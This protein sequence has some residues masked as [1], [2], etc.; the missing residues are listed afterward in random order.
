MS[1][2]IHDVL[3]ELR[4]AA[5]D[6][7][8]KGDKFERLI[9]GYLRTDPQWARQFDNVWLWME[10]PGREGRPDTGIDLVASDRESGELTAIQCKF[11]APK[12]VVQK[13]DIDS[14]FTA[15]GK[16]SFS[17]RIVVS[18]TDKWSK[19]AQES[20]VDQQ[21]S[22]QRLDISWLSESTI[23]WDA[24][25]WSTP[26]VMPTKGPK[27]LLPH[28][29]R[30][31][32]HVRK[33]LGEVDR[34]ILIMACGTGKTFTS[35]KIAEELVGA[36][37]SVLFLVPSI[38]LLSQAL[39]EWMQEASASLRP[40]AVCS[41]VRVGRRQTEDMGVI[42]LTEP[43]TTSVAKLLERMNKSSSDERMT[44]IFSTYQSI[45]VV[46]DA[47]RAGLGEFELVICDE[48]HRTTGVT[49]VGED[50]SAFVRVHDQGFLRAK[51]RLYMTATPRLYD[52]ASKSKAAEA[53]V[54]I[55]SMD[56][57]S[58]YGP[59]LHRLGFGEA[60][61]KGLLADYKVLVL[62]VD[63]KSV[64][65]QFQ[66]LL[67]DEN[68]ELTL[69]D[70]AKIVGCWNGLAKRELD[71]TRLHANTV[72]MR[73]AV[74][75]AENIKVSQKI[76]RMFEE[77]TDQLAAN[78]NEDN[79][80]TCEAEH[81]DGTFN[82]LKRNALL[83]WLKDNQTDGS[84][85]CRIL[86]N[87]RCLSEGVDVP[88]LDAV[89]FL[90]PRNSVVDVVQSVG[91]VMR[92]PAGKEYGY[93]IL[94]IGIPADVPPEQ[95]LADNKR[96]RVVWQVLQALRAH[97]DRFN[98]MVNKIE[99]NR[100]KD[101]QLQVIG[102]GGTGQHEREPEQKGNYQQGELALSWSDEWCD[103]IY[104][105]IVE[106]VGDRRYW[107]TWA[108]D[109]AEIAARHESRIKALLEHPN[110]DVGNL[111]DR[112]H[113]GLKA[114]LNDGITRENAIEMLAQH[115]ITK[116]VFGALFEGYDF[117]GH[118]PI[119]LVMQDMLDALDEQGI[120][121]E[122]ETLEK[123]YA[124][125]QLRAA[126]I[127]NAEGKQK[128]INDLYEK[129]FKTAFPKAAASLGIVYTPIQI[130]DFIL[131]SV[132]HL[133]GTEFGSSLNNEDV[134]VLDPFTGT[135]TFIARLLQSGLISAA[136]LL[137][138]YA[139]ELH[140]NE[141]NLLAYYIAAVNIEATFHGIA[142]GSYQPFDGIVLTDTFQMHEENDSLDSLIF[143]Q[144]NERVLRQLATP[145]R[146]IV[147]NPPYSAGQSSANDDNANLK[148]PTLDARIEG[149]YAARSTATL[150]N[151]LYDSYIRAIRWASDRIG[152]QGIVAFVSNGGYIDSNTA[153]GLRKCLLDEFDVV[154]V[155]NLR[156][157]QRTAGELSRKEGGKIFGGGSRATIAILFLV[158]T[159]KN[160]PGSPTVLHYR[161]I[162]DYLTREQK[163]DIVECD[164][165]E[166]I[167]W[168]TIT[169]NA[170]GDWINQ[171]RT[172]YDAYIPIGDKAKQA[173]F[174]LYS[175]GLNTSRDSWSY[176]FS[177][178]RLQGV[179]ARSI[180]FFNSEVKRFKTSASQDA[181]RF[182]D[183]DPAKFSWDVAPL[184]DVEAG[185]LIEVDSTAFR[186]ACYRPFTRSN[187]YFDRRLV[188]RVYQLPRC[189][190]T[191]AQMNVG[192]YN[193]GAGSDV[194]FSVLMLDCVPDRH[195]TGA[196]SGGNFYPRYIYRE[197]SAEANL[198]SE[199]AENLAYQRVDNIT[200]SAL[201][202]FQASYG[203]SVTKDDIFFY[204][205]GL[206]HSP[207]YRAQ[208]AAD[209]K[210]M[211]PRIP[212]VND[213]LGFT[214]AGRKL[215]DLHLGYEA[216]EL[217]ELQEVLTG[218]QD[219]D[220]Y[221]RYRVQKM[222]FD[223]GSRVNGKVTRDR[224]RIV[225]N[226][227]ITLAGIPEDAYGYM[228]GSRSAIEWIMDRYQIRTDPSSGIVNDP[229]N[230]A[231]EHEQ[232]RYILDL[233][234]RIVTVSVATMR[235]AD[236]LPALDILS[237]ESLSRISWDK[238]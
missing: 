153:D 198:F 109:I 101:A 61:E 215:A 188:N 50:E 77:V 163:L 23:E 134:H 96:Y 169:P 233:L 82:V 217:Y 48:A 203:P 199:D 25:S 35:L 238:Q 63:Q 186:N 237:A 208:Y 83:D 149:T 114:N 121:K 58:L 125:V 19:H 10:W 46:S 34:G 36:G 196:G 210:K 138:K 229:N 14:F 62:A 178:P 89:L 214:N 160:A 151:S 3:A 95:A 221:F 180:D 97:D 230:W 200:D 136:N 65:A 118:N 170:H 213:F 106:K 21:I 66:T 4:S 141:I 24:F 70:A 41:D 194:P 143:P 187:V 31:L 6:E 5:L 72:P 27:L 142:G 130:V 117:T 128:I 57:E 234:K 105:K 218:T 1:A 165:I 137:R 2:T 42:D 155:Y 112:F 113:T 15:S 181:A 158:K 236:N 87:A 26:T 32:Q 161:D 159:G 235:I 227:S 102:V 182:V 184:R 85:V 127:D 179:V 91:R 226:S 80:L 225:Y 231:R 75:F 220:E 30:A 55:A 175:G 115:I 78:S 147:G 145:I 68:H 132:E 219:A 13:H 212:K 12:Y 120:D 8:D 39:R 204:V 45:Q 9:Q 20:L 122:T 7:R 88:A 148:Y 191:C 86:S 11:Y 144:N 173:I 84:N 193:V 92:K 197:V 18:T 209:L 189:F 37:G 76:V 22:T 232:P 64:S 139:G 206:L 90:N 29:E 183:R 44:V 111:F 223:K 43:A 146:V 67:A 202:D 33:G 119:S 52:D 107:E 126:D 157:N 205:Y 224:T 103:A 100:A 228:L 131:R 99:L 56:N 53:N 59:E 104:A 108:S 150:K 167:N 69:D 162:G 51:K 40:F 16:T 47:Q 54:P 174:G 81:V 216:A 129:F 207:T 222:A 154:Y 171:R 172:D 176:N 152:D 94:P 133:L 156:G 98:A 195:V 110:L 79:P 140:A 168:Q 73:R 164:Y 124:S 211:L 71:Q 60:V 166:D 28:Q 49:L 123:F 190:P 17:R 38:S 93:V 185:R 74:A 201:T 116:P 192:I 135:G 177:L